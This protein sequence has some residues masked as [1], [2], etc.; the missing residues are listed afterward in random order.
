MYFGMCNAL[1]MFQRMMDVLFW[2]VLTSGRVF[3]YIDDVLITSDDLGELRYWTHEVLMIMRES[4]LSC[5]PVKCQF[6][7]QSVKY[8]G[9]I[10]GYG[11]TTINPKKAE[12][13]AEWPTPQNLK[14]VQSF[15]GTCNF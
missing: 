8:L 14:D 7:Q 5:K 11:Q 3:I 4:C 6:E 9:T 10:I 12:V 15:L 1:A 2:K 13:I